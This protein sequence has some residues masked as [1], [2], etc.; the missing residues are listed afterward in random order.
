[1]PEYSSL[2][3]KF[4]WLGELGDVTSEQFEVVPVNDRHD[5]VNLTDGTFEN[6]MPVCST[7]KTPDAAVIAHAR[8]VGT[9]CDV[10]VYSFSRQ[11]LVDKIKALIDEYEDARFFVEEGLITSDEATRNTELG[12]IKWTGTLK[13]SL[14]ANKE[15]VFDESRIREVL[16]RPFTKLWLYEDDRI[17]GSVKT[18]SKMFPRGD[19]GGDE[20]EGVA[21]S[22]GATRGSDDTMLASGTL[23]DLN[24]LSGGGARG[25]SRAGGDPDL[26]NVEHDLPSV[27]GGHPAGP[28]RDQGVPADQG[29]AAASQAIDTGGGSAIL[30]SLTRQLPFG[31]I[32]TDRLFDLCATGRQTRCAPRRR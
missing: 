14:K 3:H 29:A 31:I 32:V 8:G 1:M 20:D 16:Y 27:G 17:L 30:V 23:A 6:L 26:G 28:G 5:W 11:A 13:Q 21:V 15:I 9:S 18:V 22:G 7:K 4:A 24:L 10:Y 25:S 2:E 19:R 12:V